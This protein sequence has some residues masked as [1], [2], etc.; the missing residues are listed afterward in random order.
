MSNK[1][2]SICNKF[3]ALSVNPTEKMIKKHYQRKSNKYLSYKN[4]QTKDLI[5]S[6]KRLT[7]FYKIKTC[8]WRI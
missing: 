6:H 5:S 3:E 7:R 2:T 8:Y 1:F 4:D